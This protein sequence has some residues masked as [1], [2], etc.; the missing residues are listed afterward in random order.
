MIFTLALCLFAIATAAGRK[1][2]E[3][4]YRPLDMRDLVK[5]KDRLLVLERTHTTH[6]HFR[7]HS[8]RILGKIDHNTYI[9]SLVARNGTYPFSPY[10]LHNVTVKIE[11]PGRPHSVYRST[12]IAGGTRV[13]KQLLAMHPQ[14]LC[15]VLYVTKSDGERGCELL[16]TISALKY[17]LLNPCQWYFYYNC[18]G[19]RLRVFSPD[20]VYDI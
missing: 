11:K 17:N 13:T 5:I 1:N 20:C 19:K 8:A 18:P 3:N 2:W 15:A 4:Y 6:T 7:C 16:A 10:N 14:G 9:Y 12:Y